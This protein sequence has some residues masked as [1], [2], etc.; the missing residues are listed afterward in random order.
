[1]NPRGAIPKPGAYSQRFKQFESE[2][3]RSET[4]NDDEASA[5]AKQL[6]I[7]AKRRREKLER[8]RQRREAKE[9]AAKEKVLRERKSR[10]QRHTEGFKSAVHEQRQKR[11]AEKKRKQTEELSA[12]AQV[13]DTQRMIMGY[14]STYDSA[15]PTADNG[16]HQRISTAEHDSNVDLEKVQYHEQMLSHALEAIRGPNSPNRRR[17]TPIHQ[18][19]VSSSSSMREPKTE[20]RSPTEINTSRAHVTDA[21][22]DARLA[23]SPVPSVDSLDGSSGVSEGTPNQNNGVGRDSFD[24]AVRTLTGQQVTHDDGHA[25]DVEP[26]MPQTSNWINRGRRAQ[27]QQHRTQNDDTI[28][29]QFFPRPPLQHPPGSFQVCNFDCIL[30]KH[31]LEPDGAC[32]LKL[33]YRC[34]LRVGF[35]GHSVLRIT[36]NGCICRASV[37]RVLV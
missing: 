10:I 20:E 24:D 3:L 30:W 7:E 4:Q 15:A 26:R 31:E 33:A 23:S 29:D 11:A 25:A 19:L 34:V 13:L 6:R 18:G 21:M 27:P 17:E 5:R 28:S 37:V 1:M 36:R 32:V 9:T 16:T 8:Q 14:D 12:W 22:V 35:T 2:R